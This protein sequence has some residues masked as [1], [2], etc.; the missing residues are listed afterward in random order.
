MSNDDMLHIFPFHENNL[1]LTTSTPYL[2]DG[3]YFVPDR[4]WLRS[5]IQHRRPIITARGQSGIIVRS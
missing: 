5:E 3:H 1:E 2:Q 4:N